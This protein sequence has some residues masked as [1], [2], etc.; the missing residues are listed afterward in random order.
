M[1]TVK[2]AT[3]EINLKISNFNKININDEINKYNKHNT[4]NCYQSKNIFKLLTNS[5]FACFIEFSSN[6]TP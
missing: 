1:K 3:K 2:V 5:C 4:L 6:D